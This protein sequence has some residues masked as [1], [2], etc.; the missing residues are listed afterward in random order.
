MSVSRTRIV[1]FALLAAAMFCASRANAQEARWAALEAKVQDLYKQEDY[2]GATPLA[3]EELR[4]AVATFGADDPNTARSTKNLGLLYEKQSKFADAEPLL[5]RALEIRENALGPEDP[6]VAESLGMLAQLYEKESKYAE[7]EPLYKRGLAIDERALGSDNTFV[8]TFLGNLAEVYEEEG[9]YA[10]AEPL[11]QR[12]LSIDEKT[13]G[14]DDPEVAAD[15]NNL[16]IL[17]D[18]QGNYRAEEPLL[19]RALKINEKAAGPDDTVVA[20]AMNNLA[21]A[22]VELGKYSDAEPLLKQSLAIREK[23]LG[24]G[25][26]DVATAL[27]NL[28]E[29]LEHEGIYGTA[30]PMLQR[31][32]KIDQAALG[33]DHP[34]VATDLNNL[35]SLDQIEGKYAAAEPLFLRSLKIQEK[36]LGPDHPDVATTLSNLGALYG[37]QGRYQEARALLQRAF[38][39]DEAA[40]NP[41][42]PAIAKDLN[43][44]ATVSQQQG[45][46]GDAEQAMKLVLEIDERSLGADSPELASALENLGAIYMDENKFADAEPV[47]QR[48]LE[49]DEKSLGPNHPDLA[50]ALGGLASLDDDLGKYSDADPLYQRALHIQETALGPEHPDLAN[51]ESNFAENYDAQGRFSDAEPLFQRVFANLFRQF[52]YNFTYMTEKQRL[53]FLSTVDSYFQVYFS[54]VY[55]YYQKDPALAGT[56]YNLL[57]WEKGFVANSIAGMRRAIET[58]GDKEAL[59]LLEELSAKRTQVAALLNSRPP[60]QELWRKQIEQLQS[61]SDALEKELVARSAAFATKQKLDRATWQQVRDALKPGEAAVEF[62]RFQYFD[63]DWTDKSYYVALVVTSET[64]D[65]PEYIVLGDDKEIEGGALTGFKLAV[66]TRGMSAEEATIPGDKAYELIW[67]P[68]EPA[69]EGKTRIYVAADGALNEIPLGVIP[70]PDGK[71]QMERFDL[72]LVS[73]TKDLLRPVTVPTAKAALLVGDPAFDE[74]VDQQ[75]TA[76]EKL[77]AITLRT[78]AQT[79]ELPVAKPATTATELPLLPGTGAEVAAIAEL[80]KGSGWKTGIYERDTALKSVVEQSESP[81]V[82]HLATHGFF[83]PDQTIKAGK[84]GVGDKPSAFED[85]MLRSGLYFAGADRTLAGIPAPSGLD[86]G[87][88]TALEAGNLDLRGT[89]LVV[90]SACNTGQGDVKNGEGVFGLRRALQEAGAQD[91]LMSLWSVPDK[92]TLELMQRFYAKWLGGMEKHEALKQAQLEIREEVKSSHGGKDLPFYWGAFILVGK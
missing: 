47:I 21:E 48:S 66:Q 67:K 18:A 24:A 25:D 5:K 92:E 41:D 11:Y 16:A 68:L 91:V 50:L 76:V 1:G 42:A 82:V 65:Q 55:R 63:K 52:Q 86:N 72:R 20:E 57:L 26:P 70:G 79:E 34:T 80:M 44:L 81:R 78:P 35:A 14:P 7:A 37:D 53:Q 87:V 28:A 39:I 33:A 71:L 46:Y 74:S 2:A 59:K 90:L 84:R 29:L 3:V 10:D 75:K 17:Y 27:T 64:K 36:A 8:T 58:S 15:L 85:P 62:A 6:L 73:S 23:K 89:E 30:E 9:K 54:F 51:T 45:A 19:E 22:Y 60:D 56:T 88:L 77:G 32:L 13:L 69:L 49:I 83:L 38:K 31:A 43:N 40:L 12:A 61:E 4:V